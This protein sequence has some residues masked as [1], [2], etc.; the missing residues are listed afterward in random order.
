MARGTDRLGVFAAVA[1]EV[2]QL[3]G[4]DVTSMIR[5]DD[6][7][8][9]IVGAW[10]LGPAPSSPLGVRVSM[11]EDSTAS[12]VHRT[13]R[14]ARVDIDDL[15]RDAYAEVREQ[16]LRASVGAPVVVHGELWGA[17]VGATKDASFPPGAEQR[18]AAFAELVAQALANAEAREELAASRKRLVAAAQL[19]RRRLERN[20][21]DGAQ[22]RLVGLSVT[23]RLAERRLERDPEAARAALARASAELSEAL[24]EL[25]ELARGLHPA[26]LTDH[27]LQAALRALA[28]RAP[29]PVDLSVHL[30]DRPPEPLEEAAYFVVAEALTNVARYASARTASV[31]VR[32]EAD[33][34]LVEVTDDGSGGA[35]PDAGSGLRGLIDRVEALG[36]RLEVQSPADRGT[37]VRAWLPESRGTGGP[38]P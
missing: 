16:G 32:R 29:L 21:H 15:P 19:E 38:W 26:V 9:T 22:Q 28:D 23:L 3:F 6:G 30:D 10:S 8:G 7:H 14:P 25:R 17:V 1:E 4:A 5:F 13:G 36:G 37:T 27:G 20:L 34:V 24:D 18:V 11:E 12:R 2:G 31:I 33:D 35:D